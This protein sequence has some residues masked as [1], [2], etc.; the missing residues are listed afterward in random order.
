MKW[1][2]WPTCRAESRGQDE[3]SERSCWASPAPPPRRQ[4]RVSLLEHHFQ[5]STFFERPKVSDLFQLSLSWF[6]FML[7]GSR[8]RC[9]ST[10][11]AS[12]FLQNLPGCPARNQ[13]LKS[14]SGVFLRLTAVWGRDQEPC[15]PARRAIRDTELCLAPAVHRE[16][17]G[18][19]S[20]CHCRTFRRDQRHLVGP[21]MC[22]LARWCVFRAQ[23]L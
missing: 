9:E 5:C 17:E 21:A 4:Y 3:R 12:G 18:L 8:L 11:I 22:T 20:F 10:I 7:G 16:V 23:G 14:G 19:G 15:P 1:K 13:R 6:M 2:F